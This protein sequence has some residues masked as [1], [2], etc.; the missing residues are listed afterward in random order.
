MR[1]YATPDGAH[2]YNINW[3]YLSGRKNCLSIT[4]SNLKGMVPPTNEYNFITLSLT[5]CEKLQARKKSQ[6][7]TTFPSEFHKIPHASHRF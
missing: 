4:Y 5:L 3:C 2:G 1:E 7:P 6:G